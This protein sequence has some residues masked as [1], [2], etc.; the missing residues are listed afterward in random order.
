MKKTDKI[1]KLNKLDKYV[2]M[3]NTKFY[4]G[5]IYNGK[6]IDLCDDNESFNDDNGN[7]IY[8]IHIRQ[9]IKRDVL[10]TDIESN[11]IMKNGKKVKQIEHQELEIEKGQKL[12]YLE[13]RG[14]TI[15]EYKIVT[16]DEAKKLYDL[17]K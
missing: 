14:F 17:L 10:Y 9:I 12:I 3:P 2:V 11:T 8:N 5:F 6:D 7:E 16:I 15:S 1:E 4:G 13:D